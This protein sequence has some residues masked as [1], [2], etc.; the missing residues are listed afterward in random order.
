M[1]PVISTI[2]PMLIAKTCAFFAYRAPLIFDIIATKFR[3]V[4]H[5]HKAY[6]DFMSYGPH[7]GVNFFVDKVFDIV[8][9]EVLMFEIEAD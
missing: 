7:Y 1:L 3:F 5:A 8:E 4:G 9:I 2:V 6:V